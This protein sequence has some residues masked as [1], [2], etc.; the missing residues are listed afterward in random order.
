MCGGML[1]VT[2]YTG[3]KITLNKVFLKSVQANISYTLAS[4]SP[5]FS[6]DMH[7]KDVCIGNAALNVALQVQDI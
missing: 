3:W 4:T 6:Q 5:D 7:V 1:D 2:Q